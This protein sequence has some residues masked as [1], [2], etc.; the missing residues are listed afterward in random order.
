MTT[1]GRLRVFFIVVFMCLPLSARAEMF[2]CKQPNGSYA[3]QDSPCEESATQHV[4]SVDSRGNVKAAATG[5]SAVGHSE[6]VQSR[7]QKSAPSVPAEIDPTETAKARAVSVREQPGNSSGL[8]EIGAKVLLLVAIALLVGVSLLTF[9]ARA[10]ARAR[11][12]DNGG[13]LPAW[14]RFFL[15]WADTDD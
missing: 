10:R 8:V 13:G 15:F 6:L 14:L 1:L 9:T 2:K 11:I 12:R 3:Y 4:L 5:N 7:P